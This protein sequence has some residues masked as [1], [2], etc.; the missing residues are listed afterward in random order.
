[1]VYNIQ[2][3]F[4]II[5]LTMNRMSHMQSHICEI[6]IILGN[7]GVY[8]RVIYH[9]YRAVVSLWWKLHFLC[10]SRFV[11]VN[12]FCYKVYYCFVINTERRFTKK[13]TKVSNVYICFTWNYRNQDISQFQMRLWSK[14]EDFTTLLTKMICWYRLQLNNEILSQPKHYKC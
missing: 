7:V 10:T 2:D 9:C 12:Y 5:E 11:V 1:M 3:I 14:P 13:R 4:L 8:K 6:E